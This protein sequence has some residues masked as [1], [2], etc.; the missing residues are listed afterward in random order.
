MATEY[1]PT[2]PGALMSRK[3]IGVFLG[4]SKQRLHQITHDPSFPRPFAMVDDGRTPIW[5]RERILKWDAERKAAAAA[6]P[7]DPPAT[8]RHLTAV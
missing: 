4:L 1:K 6:A 8:G 7:P 2:S 5:K 3:D